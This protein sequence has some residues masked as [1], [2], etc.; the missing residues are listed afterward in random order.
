MKE[1]ISMELNEIKVTV[2]TEDTRFT[3]SADLYDIESAN[4]TETNIKASAAA[5]AAS[6]TN[7]FYVKKTAPENTI[8]TVVPS[9]ELILT[10]PE[11]SES[12]RVDRILDRV[13][14]KAYIAE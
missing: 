13:V 9:G 11:I 14:M 5:L 2:L 6:E 7:E 10:Q 1:G 12:A 3:L 8:E 4:A